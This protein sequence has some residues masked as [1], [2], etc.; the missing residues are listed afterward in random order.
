MTLVAI[1]N[2]IVV[3][4]AILKTVE[5]RGLI[6]LARTSYR[7]VVL[8]VLCVH[9]ML[10]HTIVACSIERYHQKTTVSTLRKLSIKLV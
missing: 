6:K 7:G 10:V 5:W 3:V 8:I 9:T 1:A 4:G 2:T